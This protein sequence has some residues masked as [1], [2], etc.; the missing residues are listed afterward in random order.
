LLQII[1]PLIREFTGAKPSATEAVLCSIV[2]LGSG[3]PNLRRAIQSDSQ[4][5]GAGKSLV[6]DDVSPVDN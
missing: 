6:K 1:D 2:R 5:N 4:S 3:Q